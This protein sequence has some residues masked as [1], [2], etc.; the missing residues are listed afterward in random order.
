MYLILLTYR[1]PLEVINKHLKA[2]RNFLDEGYKN[3]FFVVSGPKI[4]R[5]GGIILSQLKSRTQL[6][7]ILRQ[8][9][10]AIYKVADYEIIEFE[11]TKYHPD[12]L[13]FVTGIYP[14]KVE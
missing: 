7:Q 10:F 3:N 1:K 13:P 8:D 4:P 14:N 5:I 12:F 9:P 2:H 11:P 6:K